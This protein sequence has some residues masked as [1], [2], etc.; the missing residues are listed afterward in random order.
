[1]NG[2]QILRPKIIVFTFL[3]PNQHVQDELSNT[4]DFLS[5][6]ITLESSYTHTH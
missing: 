1:M 2:Q 5:P 4:K 6:D 3:S